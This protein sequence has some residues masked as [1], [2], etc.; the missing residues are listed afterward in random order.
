[1]LLPAEEKEIVQFVKNKNKA[2][3]GVSKKQ[4]SELIID[5]LS[6]RQNVS[7]KAKCGRRYPKLS[8]T[9]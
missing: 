3:Q 2:H 6:I 8:S 5:V 4:V 1:M 7:M 9:Q